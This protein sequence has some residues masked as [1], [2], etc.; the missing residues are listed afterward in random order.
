MSVETASK[1][2]DVDVK[3]DA[4]DEEMHD[5]DDEK[6]EPEKPKKKKYTDWPLRD[7]KEPHEHDVL[8][9]RGGGMCKTK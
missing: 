4:K 8:Y 5:A 3:K 9:G 2:E 6:P 7:I 1:E